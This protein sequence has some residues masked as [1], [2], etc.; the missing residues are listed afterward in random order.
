ME[1]TSHLP[2]GDRERVE[3]RLRQNLMA[4]LATVRP[5]G[6]PVSVP[7]WF[8]LREDETI[9][10]YSQPGTQKLR[11]IAANPK[12]SLGLDVTDI[13]R[14][15]VRME[16][17]ARQVPDQPAANK[18]AEYLA[19]YTERIGALFGTPERFAELFS[20]ALIITPTKL[21]I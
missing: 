12:V 20:A 1:L 5:D 13:G 4:W 15:I 16:G 10:L 11:N 7:V 19:K 18:Q 14:N 3:A 9:L 8:L 17:I 2:A 6:Q 21:H